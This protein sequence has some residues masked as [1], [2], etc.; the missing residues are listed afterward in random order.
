MVEQMANPPVRNQLLVG[1][2]PHLSMDNIRRAMTKNKYVLFSAYLALNET[3]RPNHEEAVRR[4]R[5][6]EAST[7]DPNGAITQGAEDSMLAELK[8]ARRYCAL[9]GEIHLRKMAMEE[10]ENKNYEAAK[11][12]GLVQDCGCCFTETSLNRMVSCEGD[13]KHFFCIECVRK[14]AETLVGQSRYQLECLSL[15]GC[16]AGF[17]SEERAKF[18]DNG[19]AAALERIEQETMLR[20][21]N[22]DNLV[23]CP[24][25]PFAA[26]CSS[27]EEDKE[28]HCQNSDCEI[29]SCRLCKAETHVPLSCDEAVQERGCSARQQIEEAMSAAMIRKCNKCGTPF[30]KELGCN[31][32]T[33]SRADC[34]NMQCYVCSK[35]C[36]YNH[37]DERSQ[38]REGKAKG[39]CP[40]FDDS[41]LRHTRE[42]DAAGRQTRL[43]LADE[44]PELDPQY[45]LIPTVSEKKVKARSQALN[46]GRRPHHNRRALN[47]FQGQA[48]A[49]QQ[50]MGEDEDAPAPQNEPQNEPQDELGNDLLPQGPRHEPPVEAMVFRPGF[51]RNWRAPTGPIPWTAPQVFGPIPGAA[52]PGQLANNRLE[53]QY[54]HFTFPFGTPQGGAMMEQTRLTPWAHVLP[55]QALGVVQPPQAV[56]FAQPMPM[57]NPNVPLPDV[58]NIQQEGEAA[59]RRTRGRMASAGLPGTPDALGTPAEPVIPNVHNVPN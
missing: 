33:C 7:A 37:F 9:Q 2:F 41:N 40:L 46:R 53:H 17:S 54:Y 51:G 14:L 44:H 18:L 28:F 6:N 35:S 48:E 52:V 30:I 31:K 47:M 20:S 34:G 12:R 42:V 45:L 22:L 13:P 5:M 3:P 19:L 59:R 8:E 39:R 10:A 38:G 57:P 15:D 11:A 49:I 1:E 50:N 23:M 29:V 55:P 25:C 32:V 58:Q 26:E 56:G 36:D 4:G 24:F 21:A 16:S 27:V 43:R